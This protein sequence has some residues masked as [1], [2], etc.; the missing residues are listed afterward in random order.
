MTSTTTRKLQYVSLLNDY[1]WFLAQ[2]KEYGILA[3]IENLITELL[4]EIDKE[5]WNY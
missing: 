3:G 1:A 2:E 5:R 4:D